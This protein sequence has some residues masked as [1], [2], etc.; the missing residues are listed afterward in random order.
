MLGF[1]GRQ[2]A[3]IFVIDQTGAAEKKGEKWLDSQ[4]G[5]TLPLAFQIR[6]GDQGI[7][8]GYIE[9]SRQDDLPIDNRRYFT[10]SVRDPYQI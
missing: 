1:S 6:A 8:Q 10:I 5:E 2:L 9:L 7:L 3:E 4:Q